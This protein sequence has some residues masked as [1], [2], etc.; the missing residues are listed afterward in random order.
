MEVV[1]SKRRLSS[2][3]RLPRGDPEH[4]FSDEEL[5]EKFSQNAGR[6]LSQDKIEEIES[7]LFEKEDFRIR[8]LTKL[9]YC[10]S[11]LLFM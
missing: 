4:P 11:C 3:V 10:I 8:D 9:V 2:E 5:K 1:T 7:I 6:V